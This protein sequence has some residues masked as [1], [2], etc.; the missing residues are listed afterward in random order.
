MN[1]A[2]TSAPRGNDRDRLEE[3][4]ELFD[5]LLDTIPD[6]IYF[7]DRESRFIRVSRAKA[8]RHGIFDPSALIGKS[9]ADLFSNEH[10]QAAFED[11]QQ[12]IKTGEGVTGKV[13]KETLPD[14]QVCWA[15][16]TKM[17]L[18]N[19]RGEIVGTYGISK[20]MTALKEMEDALAKSN[21]DLVR[22]IAELKQT[23]E[24]LKVAQTRLIEAEKMETAARLAAG[25]AHEVRNPLNILSAGIDYLCTDPRFA[26]DPTSS[27]VLTELQEAIRRAD[28][29]VCALMDSSQK[30]TLDLKELEVDALLNKALSLR[31]SQM[32]KQGIKVV[33]NL[34]EDLPVLKL[35]SNKMEAVLDGLLSNSIDAMS[36]KPGGEI[37]IGTRVKQLGAADVE[38]DSGARAG[39]RRHAGDRVVLIEI[40]DNGPGIPMESLHDIFDPFYTTKKTGTGTGLGLT[41]CRKLLELQNGS[42]DVTNRPE[43]GVRVT[44]SL[45]VS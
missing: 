37:H 43:G 12:I 36:E 16:T 26:D 4:C 31:A 29:V 32:E 40:E 25:V 39:Q 44:I 17:P 38:Y 20:D 11:E 13:E 8:V 14:G 42:I 33:R 30:G 6:R 1:P 19:S 10:A 45:R 9:D 2:D 28:T 22:T 34:A 3:A 24:A 21:T 27:T 5:V 15:F 35:D 41:V 7:K 18:R 23:H